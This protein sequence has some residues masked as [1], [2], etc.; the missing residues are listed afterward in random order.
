MYS[1]AKIL[2]QQLTHDRSYNPVFYQLCFLY[3]KD[4]LLIFGLCIISSRL[5]DFTFTFDETKVLSSDEDFRH[6]DISIATFLMN[7]DMFCSYKALNGKLVFVVKSRIRYWCNKAYKKVLYL[8]IG[9]IYGIC[10]NKK[11]SE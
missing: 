3:L 5:K 7:R 2:S 9:S 6:P 10:F 8:V 4:S 1:Y 11:I